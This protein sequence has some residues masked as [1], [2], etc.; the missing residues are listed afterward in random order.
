MANTTNLNMVKPA[1]TDH[2]LI[3]VINSNMDIIDGAVGALPSGTTLQGEIDSANT[4]IGALQ[5]FESVTDWNS[6]KPTNA[7]TASRRQGVSSGGTATG[8]PFSGDSASFF[9]YVEGTSTYCT[10]H[11]TCQYANTATNYNRSFVR[12]CLGGTWTAWKELTKTWH[13]INSTT[14]ANAITYDN[15]KSKSLDLT[16]YD[17]VIIRVQDSSASPARNASV[18]IPGNY[19]GSTDNYWYIGGFNTASAGFGVTVKATKNSV[20]IAGMGANGAAI[21][22]S[23][24][25]TLVIEAR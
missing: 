16:E 18:N 24:S 11:L 12:S 14:G 10:Q 9:G 20:N 6:F 3:S 23:S 19:F 15:Y 17:D 13:R 21:T 7:S 2:A 22:P 5:G 4:A 1:G 8:S 25:Q